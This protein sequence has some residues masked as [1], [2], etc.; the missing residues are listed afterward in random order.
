MA[1]GKNAA[2]LFEVISKG[3]GVAGRKPA[4]LETPRWWFRSKKPADAPRPAEDPRADARATDRAGHDAAATTSVQ[5]SSTASRAAAG[6]ES[7]VGTPSSAV[8]STA[9][10]SGTPTAGD[11]AGSL[12]IGDAH[13]T[14]STP[15][16]SADSNAP[17]APVALH[18][19]AALH[20][21]AAQTAR[22]LKP[23]A[24]TSPAS[25][26]VSAAATPPA[27]SASPTMTVVTPADGSDG[28]APEQAAD[29][30][31]IVDRDRQ[32][33]S[34][35]LSFTSV[36]VIG[37]AVM[38]AFVLVW[39]A[40]TAGPGTALEPQ[41]ATPTTEDIR[42]STPVPGVRDV[43]GSFAASSSDVAVLDTVG[44]ESGG[45]SPSSLDRAELTPRAGLSDAPE[46]ARATTPP[47][48]PPMPPGLQPT[49]TADAAG[50]INGLNYLVIQ[51]YP[52][53]SDAEEAVKALAD[54]GIG[55]TIERRLRGLNPSWHIVV[56]NE[57]FPRL[58]GPEYEAYRKKILAVS[59][60]L[61]ASRRGAK[62]F[63]I[64][65][66]KWDRAGR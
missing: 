3:K 9:L 33:I 59:E 27:A 54:A 41:L 11:A 57:G 23:T 50:R 2:A 1:K 32:M 19:S 15:S 64:Q 18:T 12:R 66:Y 40:R 58:R 56:G 42:R 39:Y 13:P 30:A 28:A 14:A 20:P 52:E 24:S 55:A 63:E 51:G 16:A 47:A 6:R 31:V 36:V 60:K 53:K 38:V 43:D 26:T 61:T 65:G 10:S 22:V 21:P 29:R 34:L 25:S 44:A 8:G 62:P 7:A 17:A 49:F 4:S 5:A 48:A 46:Q 45:V 37:F 35:H